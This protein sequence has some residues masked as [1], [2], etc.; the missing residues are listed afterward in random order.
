MLVLFSRVYQDATVGITK[1]FT[2]QKPVSLPPKQNLPNTTSSMMSL[3][4]QR[5]VFYV[6]GYPEEFDVRS[7]FNFRILFFNIFSFHNSIHRK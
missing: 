7:F 6:G 3:D 1:N 5:A 2:S 4:S